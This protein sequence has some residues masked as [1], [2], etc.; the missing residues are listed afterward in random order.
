MPPSLVP[1]SRETKNRIG[2]TLGLRGGGGREHDGGK[3]MG[4]GCL[5]SHVRSK[6]SRDVWTSASVVGAGVLTSPP[7]R[8]GRS[9]ENCRVPACELVGLSAWPPSASCSERVC[10]GGVVELWW[11]CCRRRGCAALATTSAE[12]QRGLNANSRGCPTRLSAAR[13]TFLPGAYAGHQLTC[14]LTARYR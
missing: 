13:R 10:G 8:M 14:S 5:S 2:Q 6:R 1:N 12:G 4:R 11:R 3:L 7:L 9:G